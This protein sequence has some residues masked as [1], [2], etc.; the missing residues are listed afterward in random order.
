MVRIGL[1]AGQI[2]LLNGERMY[3]K[4]RLEMPWKRRARKKKAAKEKKEL[5]AQI[6]ELWGSPC[7]TWCVCEPPLELFSGWKFT[8]YREEKWVER[9]MPYAV[10]PHFVVLGNAECLP[11][12]LP[13]Y[14]R[15]M[16][17]LRFVLRETDITEA[18]E[19]LLEE[20]L[21]EY[22]IAANILPLE[23]QSDYR[24]LQMLCPFP[25]NVLDFSGEE[26]ISSSIVPPGSIWLD[27][28]ADWEKWRRM[29]LRGG[30]VRYVSLKKEW[31]QAQKEPAPP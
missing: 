6:E 8:D 18:L 27:F 10:K 23:E 22:G 29:E 21:L 16:K 9:L 24:R 5:L 26:K 28:S 17:G 11:Y 3:V 1:N 2:G 30:S 12:V 20:L 4:K 13:R 15:R 7:E 25:C 14:A 31:K 19:E